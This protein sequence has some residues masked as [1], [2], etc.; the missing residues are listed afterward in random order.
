MWACM[1]STPDYVLSFTLFSGFHTAQLCVLYSVGEQ[2]QQKNSRLSHKIALCQRFRLSDDW[3]NDNATTVRRCVRL[4]LEH[5]LLSGRVLKLTIGSLQTRILGQ[6]MSA[7]SR[8]QIKLTLIKLIERCTIL[9]DPMRHCDSNQ[10][11]SS[12]FFACRHYHNQRLSLD[13]LAISHAVIM[14]DGNEDLTI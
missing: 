12:Y 6:C 5:K 9:T 3:P 4:M 1:A 11:T 10:L 8:A 7:F 14:T 2:S 13:H